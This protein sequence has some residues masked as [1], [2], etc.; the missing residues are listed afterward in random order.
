MTKSTSKEHHDSQKAEV[1][2]PTR[3]DE[4]AQ[5]IGINPPPPVPP[6]NARGGHPKRPHS[7]K[8]S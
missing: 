2:D 8:T 3:G 5:S 1:E 7:G 6:G 4:K